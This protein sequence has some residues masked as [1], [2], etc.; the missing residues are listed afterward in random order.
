[1]K[2]AF[3]ILLI[4]AFILGIFV[5]YAYADTAV[6]S[7][8]KNDPHK[9][10]IEFLHGAGVV[11]GYPDGTFQ[12]NRTLNRAEL[13]KL[14]MA[15]NNLLEPPSTSYKNCFPDVQAEWYAR[16]ICYAKSQGWVKGYDDGLFHPEKEV[17]KVE[18]VKMMVKS[19]ELNLEDSV[20]LKFK[21]VSKD[22][23]YFIYLEIAASHGLLEETGDYYYP[24]N[25]M[26][27]GAAAE[28]LYRLITG[29]TSDAEDSN[30]YD[31]VVTTTGKCE[32]LTTV[33][34]NVTTV[35]NV[36]QLRAATLEANKTGNTTILLKDGTYNFD[37]E[38]LWVSG[39]NIIF[40]SE[41]GN[42]DKVILKGEGMTGSTSRIF[43]LAGDNLTVADMTLGYVANHVIQVH[44]ELDTDYALLHNLHIVDS[45][46]QLVKVSYDANK[47]ETGADNGILECSTLQYTAGI[48]P[49]YYI[50]GID[51]HNAAN[52]IVRDNL[53]SSVRSPQELLAEQTVHF[54]SDSKNATVENNTFLNCDRAIGFGMGEDRGAE[55]GIIR[56][57]KIYHDSTRGDVGIILETAKNVL[58]ENN[59]I[60]M[61]ND[62]ANA[63]EYRFKG[64]TGAQILNNISNK[65]IK[66]R[67][68]ATATL[69]G[70]ITNAEISD[71]ADPA[72]GDFTKL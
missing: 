13:L 37:G 54:W 52:W 47:M 19:N 10:A 36:A 40:R 35:S 22:S 68:G 44:G 33:V 5:P 32:P 69:S 21:D 28:I 46:E 4:L 18:A 15:A 61:E 39:S 41:S 59:I 64:T 2:K 42:R 45:Y 50:G 65:A 43:L 3:A 51:A 25:P 31:D 62:Y 16:D 27:R 1:M 72:H 7:D 56:G 49:Q 12:P 14:A 29:E 63:I 38:G 67:D 30:T 53:F 9:E 70:N 23:W 6:F 20:S 60:L 26:T 66:Q 17:N 34:G 55:G 57:N 58:I 24:G 8:V 48:G 71:Y 11:N